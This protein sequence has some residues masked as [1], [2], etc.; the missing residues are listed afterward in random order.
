MSKGYKLSLG[1]FASHPTEQILWGLLSL[2]GA[3]TKLDA[4]AAL[5]EENRI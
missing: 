3:Q 1:S 5:P 2:L 4:R